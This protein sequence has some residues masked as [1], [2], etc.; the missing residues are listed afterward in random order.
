MGFIKVSSAVRTFVDKVQS[1]GLWAC[2]AYHLRG[3]R[4]KEIVPGEYV[5]LAWE[6]V[7]TGAAEARVPQAVRKQGRCSE[8]QR[9]RQRP[10]ARLHLVWLRPLDRPRLAGRAKQL[11]GRATGR[12]PPHPMLPQDVY[13]GANQVL[14]PGKAIRMRGREAGESAA[15][16]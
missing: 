10:P 15:G 14:L 8:V 5:A 7:E 13:Q 6:Q 2:P 16:M 1:S 3:Y 11:R 12:G 4:M 9:G